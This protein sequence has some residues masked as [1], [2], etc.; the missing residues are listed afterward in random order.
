MAVAT[1][2]LGAD[3]TPALA[4][5]VV[6]LGVFGVLTGIGLAIGEYQALII[7]LSLLAAVAVMADFRIGAVL[8]L[9]MMPV[10]GSFL[11]P[12]NMLGVTGLNPFNMVLGAT[13]LSF[14]VRG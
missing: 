5:G 10:E 11:F 9:V 1:H 14:V 13:L 7:S 12:H 6:G 2:R 3:R 8:L 4:L